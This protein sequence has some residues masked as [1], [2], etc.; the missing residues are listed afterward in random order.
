VHVIIGKND[1]ALNADLMN[2]TWLK[3]YHRAELE[4]VSNAGH[5]AMF[6]TPVWLATSVESFL[7]RDA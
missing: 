7:R 3:W 2:E 6:E 1:P 5:Y 4:T